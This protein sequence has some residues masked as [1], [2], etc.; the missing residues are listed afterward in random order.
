[1]LESDPG[2][3]A[4]EEFQDYRSLMMNKNHYIHYQS[5]DELFSE[6]L[7][8][9]PK[10]RMAFEYLMISYLMMKDVVH[11]SNYLDLFSYFYKQRVPKL[12]EEALLIIANDPDQKNSLQGKKVIISVQTSMLFKN[13]LNALHIFNKQKTNSLH[14]FPEEL[15]NNYFFYYTFFNYFHSGR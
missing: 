8:T 15:R 6:L 11:F 5:I 3:A 7:K 2:L 12:F 14:Y 10:N 9:N 13:F 1:M 4:N